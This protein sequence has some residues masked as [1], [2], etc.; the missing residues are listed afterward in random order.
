MLGK[1]YPCR[2]RVLPPARG[3][4]KWKDGMGRDGHRACRAVPGEDL[5]PQAELACRL[6]SII[7]I[8]NKRLVDKDLLF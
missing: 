4:C 8:E 2:K 1:F 5:R 7:V 6:G 3:T